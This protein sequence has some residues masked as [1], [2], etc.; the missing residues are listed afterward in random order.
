[1]YQEEAADPQ[2]YELSQAITCMRSD[3]ETAVVQTLKLLMY[4][5]N[6]LWKQSI[7]K[8]CDAVARSQKHITL[9][10]SSSQMDDA[11]KEMFGTRWIQSIAQEIISTLVET[12][13]AIKGS[14]D[15]HIIKDKI[16]S[17]D[18]GEL[19]SYITYADTR[20]RL[21][22]KNGPITHELAK[23]LKRLIKTHKSSLDLDL[24]D[25]RIPLKAL[26][27]IANALQDTK[28]FTQINLENTGLSVSG[29]KTLTTSIKKAQSPLHISL[30]KNNLADAGVL[31]H[32]LKHAKMPLAID[33]SSNGIGPNGISAIADAIM[34]A[35]AP[36][37]IVLDPDLK[38]ESAEELR[39]AIMR[40][41]PPI[42][43]KL[44]SAYT[45]VEGQDTL[46]SIPLPIRALEKNWLLEEPQYNAIFHSISG[47]QRLWIEIITLPTSEQSTQNS[48]YQAIQLATSCLYTKLPLELVAWICSFLPSTEYYRIVRDL[49]IEAWNTHRGKKHSK[50][51]GC[52]VDLSEGICKEGGPES[53]YETKSSSEDEHKPDDESGKEKADDESGK[54]KADDSAALNADQNNLANSTLINNLTIRLLPANIEEKILVTTDYK[55]EYYIDNETN[56]HLE[57][58]LSNLDAKANYTTDDTHS[59]ELSDL[60]QE[61]EGLPAY[62]E[63]K[64]LVTTDHKKEYYIDN[65][66]NLHLE[67]IFRNL[68]AKENYTTDDT[69][70]VE[71]PDLF[72]EREILPA[73]SGI[74]LM[75]IA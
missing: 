4:Q 36:L 68:D 53:G 64:I 26:G 8:L 38:P 51:S 39:F 10:F 73:I 33:L 27:A 55:K 74:G 58:I 32:A 42:R 52:I 65:E 54:E 16:C 35:R 71:F 56:L 29:L 15:L 41:T 67:D 34:A 21:T 1:M 45:Q 13:R 46:C 63:E 17:Q 25:N 19:L 70:S 57:E 49:I 24:S 11:E 31:C 44:A 9:D 2:S 23:S 60:F 22:V 40:A 12:L 48:A 5:D 66:T 69:Y 28:F 75:S 3:S 20:L 59:V 43:I 50:K 72:Q 47:H 30:S 6:R 62:I 14:I 7:Q 61:K 37:I 18:I